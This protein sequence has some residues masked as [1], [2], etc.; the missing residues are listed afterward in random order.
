MLQT[1]QF[2][3]MTLTWLRGADKY[4]DAG[5]LFG[6]VPKVVWSRYYPST[7]DGLVADL[8][9]PILIAYQGRYYLIDTSLGTEKLTAKQR[10]HLG[11]IS[12]N[13]V[14]ESLAD[15]NI[16]PEAIDVVIMTHMHNDHAGGL[17]C[18]QDG[19]LVSTFPNATIYVNA[20]EWD[21]VRQ[22][23]PRMR[24]TYLRENWE[25]IQHQVV[26]FE[27]SLTLVDGIELYHT[28]GHSRGHAIILL[29]QGKETMIHMADLLLTH[30]HRNP[31]WVAGIDDYPMDCIAAKQKWLSQAYQN[32]YY[33]LF[34]HDPFYAV[35]QFDQT[36][37]EVLYCLERSRPP[38][39]SFT[40]AQDKR[41]LISEVKTID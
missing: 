20:L 35:L 25:A 29:K 28:G 34:Y 31:L 19:Q 30:A 37:Q 8:T 1:Y 21:D 33:F 5:T 13:R 26:T 17:T 39:V 2:G 38:L 4:T 41:L 3:Q 14:L 6:P 32:G 16:G 9:D 22:P 36:G 18:L 24:A 11:V 15:L 10:H 12:E 23:H 40:A 7:E 27:E